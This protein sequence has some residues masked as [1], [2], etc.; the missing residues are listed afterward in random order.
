MNK[1]KIGVIGCGNISTTYMRN[2][3]LFNNVELTA[4]ADIVP[5]SAAQ[6]ASEYRIEAMTVESLLESANVDLVLNLT[7]PTEHHRV[8]SAALDAGKHVFTEKPLAT[9]SELARELVAAARARNLALGSAPDTYLGA[10]GRMARSLIDGGGL[11]R[12]IAGTAFMM[13]HG[14]EHWHPSPEFYYQKGGGP[15]LDM[16]PYYLSMLVYLLGPATRV[17]GMASTG[18]ATRQI[19]AEGAKKNTRFAVDTETTAMGVVQFASGALV[20]VG[21]S[22]DVWKQGHAPIELY[23]ENGSLR[24]PDPDT[25]GG[26][27]QVSIKGADWETTG[28]EGRLLGAFNW[29]Y[30]MPRLANYR[31]AAVAEMA[32]AI[33][34]GRG[35]RA[36]GEF[37][38][39]VVEI[40]EALLASGRTGSAIDIASLCPKVEPMDEAAVAALLA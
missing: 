18:N 28:S 29:P 37:A 33:V 19:T 25:Y 36:S 20:T 4:C 16:G 14:M 15:V 11:G 2:A 38:L 12:I 39:H 23:G 1:I 34:A 32:N 40:L 17:V 7:I 13:G 22:W 30:D 27:V 8:T 24:L 9:S 3:A 5:A 31:M 35:P 26:D 6:R 21:M 10:A